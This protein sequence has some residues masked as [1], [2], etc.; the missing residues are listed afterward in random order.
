MKKNRPKK[1]QKKGPHAN[2]LPEQTHS[3]ASPTLSTARERIKQLWLNSRAVDSKK[4]AQSKPEHLGDAVIPMAQLAC[5]VS[6]AQNLDLNDDTGR[7]KAVEI[8]RSLVASCTAPDNFKANSG[9][10][11]KIW[12]DRYEAEHKYATANNRGW[13]GVSDWVFRFDGAELLNLE[14]L[15]AFQRTEGSFKDLLRALFP[16]IKGHDDRRSRFWSWL[17]ARSKYLG[18]S[19]KEALAE[20]SAYENRTYKGKDPIALAREVG[21]WLASQARRKMKK[22]A[23]ES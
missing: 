21:P 15:S 1:K 4:K 13:R 10:S 2:R 17:R 16:K 6:V 23:R 20:L 18:L 9:D 19:Q 11:E 7:K 22:S 8:A 5:D 12:R 14:K 3:P